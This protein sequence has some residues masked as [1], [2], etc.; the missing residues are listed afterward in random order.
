MGYVEERPWRYIQSPT[1][2]ERRKREEEEREIR[3]SLL[4]LDLKDDKLHDSGKQE[5]KTCHK[6][7]VFGKKLYA[8][9]LFSKAI[10][11]NLKFR[12]T[13]ILLDWLVQVTGETQFNTCGMAL[14]GSCSKAV[15]VLKIYGDNHFFILAHKDRW[16]HYEKITG[17]NRFFCSFWRNLILSLAPIKETR[18]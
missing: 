17:W 7:L 10:Q 3:S 12:K 8:I 6:L 16:N 15:K 14:G 4:I 1:M 2:E 11:D 5:G 9:K 18:D 13:K